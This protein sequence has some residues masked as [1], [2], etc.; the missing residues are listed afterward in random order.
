M[1]GFTPPL[2]CAYVESTDPF[3]HPA[4]LL[5]LDRRSFEHLALHQMPNE[6]NSRETTYY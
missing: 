6:T 2:C 5:E 1:L 4:A 3:S